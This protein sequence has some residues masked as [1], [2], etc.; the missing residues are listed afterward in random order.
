LD[1]LTLIRKQSQH[2]EEIPSTLYFRT[3]AGEPLFFFG[4]SLTQRCREPYSYPFAGR[5]H[6]DIGRMHHLGLH[7]SAQA[8]TPLTDARRKSSV[9]FGAGD[10]FLF[11]WLY[12]ILSPLM[13]FNQKKMVVWLFDGDFIGIYWHYYLIY[14]DL[15][16]EVN[17]QQWWL[18]EN[19]T[20]FGCD[21]QE[22]PGFVA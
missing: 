3:G 16:T 2:A 12:H 20:K 22:G 13:G 6:E 10:C 7:H 4:G 14:I 5:R 8:P 19:I 15:L 11:N 21:F 17:P 1:L 18:Y 9:S